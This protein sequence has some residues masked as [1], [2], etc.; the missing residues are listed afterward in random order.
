MVSNNK[1]RDRVPRI[2][3]GIILLIFLTMCD[4]SA[5][6]IT[7]N[8]S[9]GEDYS[10]I[11]DA[12][13]N[14]STGDTILVDRG[15]YYENVNVTKQLIMRGIGMPVVDAR[16]SGSAITLSA[17]GIRLEGFTA[18]GVGAYLEAGIK[19]TSN[20]NTLIGNIVHSNILGIYLDSS[21]SN[22]LRDNTAH[23]NDRGIQLKSSS[24]NNVSGNTA[25][26]NSEGIRLDSISTH[27]LLTGNN[28]N[29][30]FDTGIRFL[31]SSDNTLI[32]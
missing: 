22:I 26:F 17:D 6:T 23:N 28:A 1:Y 18:T 32:I 10:R 4:A 13:D 21:S 14:A 2:A 25:N 30:N 3:I 12:I 20:N 29:S 19:I 11:Q 9:V 15:T 7:V 8:A 27:N 31:D 5:E 24:N 16:G